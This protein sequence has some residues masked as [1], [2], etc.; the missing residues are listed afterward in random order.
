M[1]QAEAAAAGRPY[2]VGAS[3][4]LSRRVRSPRWLLNPTPC[5]QRGDTTPSR[6]WLPGMF[7]WDLR[8]G[9]DGGVVPA[10]EAFGGRDCGSLDH[11]PEHVQ[12][13]ALPR[14]LVVDRQGPK[15]Q[16]ALLR[17]VQ[18]GVQH[19]LLREPLRFDLLLRQVPRRRPGS[20]LLGRRAV[21]HRSRQLCLRRLH[22]HP[23]PSVYLSPCL[24]RALSLSLPRALSLQVYL[25]A[26]LSLALSLSH[27]LCR[28]LSLF[29]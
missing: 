8:R 7:L 16:A 21:R 24:C 20:Q 11:V 22:V 13:H 14:L 3:P 27:S 15:Q 12:L 2:V 9:Y 6:C 17:G 23:T 1:A 25:S 28:S 10:D 18:R 19:L 4:A 26:A 5:W 29:P